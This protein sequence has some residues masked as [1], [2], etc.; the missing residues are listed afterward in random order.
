MMAMILAAGRGERLRPLTDHTPK[1]LLRVGQQSLI[2]HHL[3]SLGKAGFNQV[4]INL[5]Y[6]G[7]QIR[8]VLGDGRRYGVVLRYSQEPPQALETGGGIFQALA[9]LSDAPFLVVNADVCTDYPFQRFSHWQHTALAHLVLV[10]KPA[11]AQ[12]G[13]F[14]L[15]QEAVSNGGSEML[16]FSGISVLHPALFDDCQAGRFSIVPLLRAACDRGCV[17]GEH[18]LGHWYDIGTVQRLQQAQA[19]WQASPCSAAHDAI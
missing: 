19:E 9:L 8:T 14:A 5:G 15:H 10:D 3:H 4:V 6:L 13:D 18:Y 7:E 11:H 12:H 16:T 2:E 1:P 17:S